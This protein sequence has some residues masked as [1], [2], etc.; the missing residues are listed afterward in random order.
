MKDE[1]SENSYYKL[2]KYFAILMNNEKFLADVKKKRYYLIKPHI[3]YI[4]DV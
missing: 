3:K 1:L 2:S 4:F